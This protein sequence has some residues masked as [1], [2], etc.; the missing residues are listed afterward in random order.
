MVM[1]ITKTINFLIN[2]SV[3]SPVFEA[4]F[5]TH[6]SNQFKLKHIN[7]SYTIKKGLWFNVK[8]SYYE[9]TPP[10]IKRY[11]IITDSTWLAYETGVDCPEPYGTQLGVILP[12]YMLWWAVPVR[13]EVVPE[14]LVVA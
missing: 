2:K 4:L 11:V 5:T 7:Q 8:I 14:W 12:C 13:L 1:Y 10:V 6:I 3:Q 9:S